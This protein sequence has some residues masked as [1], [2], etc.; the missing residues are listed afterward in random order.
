MEAREGNSLSSWVG[1]VVSRNPA[2]HR[3]G[4]ELNQEVEDC[5]ADPGYYPDEEA[6]DGPLRQIVSLDDSVDS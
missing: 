4:R 5:R 6:D 3:I 1:R 2:E